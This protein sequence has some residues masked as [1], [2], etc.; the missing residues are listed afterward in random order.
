MMRAAMA[1]DSYSR[2][3]NRFYTRHRDRHSSR[4]TI[5]NTQGSCL[6]RRTDRLT[7]S[8]GRSQKERDMEA[9]LLSPGLSG[10]TEEQL[11]ALE[12]SR[13]AREW[14]PQEVELAGHTMA[15]ELEALGFTTMEIGHMAH[16]TALMYLPVMF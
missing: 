12:L 10:D 14:A 15:Q 6:D 2:R 9:E 16:A 13:G 3:Q 8:N 4:S 11:S 1:L 5:T 7:A